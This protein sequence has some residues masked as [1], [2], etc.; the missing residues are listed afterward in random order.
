M[1]YYE[2][3]YSSYRSTVLRERMAQQADYSANQK[4]LAQLE[5]LV[6]RFAAIASRTSDPA[7]GKRLRARRSQLSR[8]KADAVEAP[9]GDAG[10]IRARFEAEA[11]RAD[12]A[13][14]IRGYSKGFGER[15]LFDDADLDVSCGERVALVGANGSGKSTLIRDIIAEGN[16]EHPVLR[17]GPSLQVGYSAQQQ[18]VLDPDKTVMEQLRAWLPMTQQAAFG[19][20]SRFHFGARDAQKRIGDL[21]G[22]ERNRLQLARLAALGPNFLI[23]DEPTNHLDIPAREAIEE[24]LADFKGT[25]L[26][27]SHDRYFL[28][29]LAERVVEIEDGKMVSFEGNFSEYWHAR[30]AASARSTGRVNQRGKDRARPRQAADGGAQGRDEGRAAELEARIQ[31]AEALKVEIE[32]QLSRA[33]ERG[34]QRE[35]KRLDKQLRQLGP[36]VAQLYEAWMALG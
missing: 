33:C 9:Q 32:A 17:V 4:R 20:L 19:F 29:K 35:G 11:S 6:K 15:I 12:I 3:G 25:I 28:D 18:E 7:W 26:V 16:W 24:A 5:D 31:E 21:S 22:G 1:R 13:L 8:E 23:L 34:D 27:V 2:G 30:K 10:K 36:R 14:Q